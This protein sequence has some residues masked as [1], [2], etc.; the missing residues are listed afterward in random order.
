MVSKEIS[1]ISVA[2]VSLKSIELVHYVRETAE[3]GNVH[4]ICASDYF[5]LCINCFMFP[6][7]VLIDT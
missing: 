1:Q 5:R 7:G 2:I 4:Q 6:V 3:T